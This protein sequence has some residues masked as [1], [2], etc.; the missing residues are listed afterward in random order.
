MLKQKDDELAQI[1]ERYQRELDS[2]TAA[3]Q[4]HLRNM[5]TKIS[6][7]EA[8]HDTKKHSQRELELKLQDIASKNAIL[9]AELVRRD[10]DQK[11]KDNG[12]HESK[13]RRRG[14]RDWTSSIS[15]S[16]Q[17]KERSCV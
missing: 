5:E 8:D 3:H 14:G 9:E 4:E 6:E 10:Q 16:K 11:E 1:K 13:D 15:S 2:N 12:T 7:V 17:K